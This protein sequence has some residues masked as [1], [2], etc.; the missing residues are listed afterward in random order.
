MIEN[1][2]LRRRIV[3][4]AYKSKA[5]HIASSLSCV[6]I[7]WDVFNN[8][9]PEDRFILSKG[10]AALALYVVLEKMGILLSDEIEK[11]GAGGLPGHP[12]RFSYDGIEFST[13]SLGHG[14]AFGAGLAYAKK[15]KD[16]P[17]I[18]YVLMG[19][20]ECQEGS[21]WEAARIISMHHLPIV[22]LIDNNMTHPFYIEGI[23]D[24]FGW[25]IG[26]KSRKL[27]HAILYFTVKG[28]GVERMEDD[29]EAWHHRQPTNEE[30]EEIM[31]ELSA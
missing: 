10:H 7:I 19:D 3:E 11:F 15:I 1:I 25:G 8:K 12:D 31:K 2:D 30:Y 18:I 6:D 28:K 20:G 4:I 17:G 13:G 23:F 27:P 16:E 9:K 26:R 21:V 29:P 24:A 5:G 22:A 14:L